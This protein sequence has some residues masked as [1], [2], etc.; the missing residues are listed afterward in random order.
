[1]PE[2]LRILDY[3]WHQVH[4]YRLCQALP[5]DFT[6]LATKPLIWN[7]AQ[8]PPA[9][10]FLGAVDPDTIDPADY[11][12]ALMHLDQ[13]CGERHNLRALPYRIM[14]SISQNLPRVVVI[15]G[16]PDNEANR[17]EIL[18]LIGDE[19]VVC[20][21]RAA[22]LEWSGGE[23]RVSRYGLPQF[24]PIIHGYTVDEFW[25]EPLEKRRREIVTICS[26]GNLSRIYHGL[27]LI[28]R[29][30]RDVPLFWLGPQGNRNWCENYDV[31]RRMLAETL[32]YFS[33]TRRAPMP[34][35]RTEAMLS[36]CCIVSVPGHDVEDY[37]V[38]GETGFVVRDY[39]Q[40]RDTLRTLL[41]HPDLAYKVG[42]AGRKVA[43]KLFTAELLRKQWLALLRDIG[44]RL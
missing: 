40:A 29:L 17:Q 3:P 1:M 4:L 26:G 35:A 27:P 5:A 33:P 6:L 22:A 13:W 23:D 41:A 44:V 10:N 16:T 42:Q 11:D 19:Q 37:V 7:A 30:M 21:S 9:P 2:R 43:R 28:E 12:L 38:N 39:V 32:I 31:Y 25:S 8:R 18:C 14:R 15:H 20:N 34:G 24:R 36:G